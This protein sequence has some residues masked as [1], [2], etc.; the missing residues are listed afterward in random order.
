M[1]HNL[2]WLGGLNVLY[3]AS[4]FD[5]DPFEPQPNGVNRI[6]PFEW[7]RPSGD[8]FV[9]MPY[10]LPQVSTLFLV[11]R[12][13]DNAIWKR[14]LDW[15]AEQGGMALLITHPD[16]MAFDEPVDSTEYPVALYEDFLRYALDRWGSEAWF[17]TCRQVAEYAVSQ[18]QRAAFI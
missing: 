4:T 7:L 9:E 11:L 10:T 2:D 8:C 15:V 5:V 6:L 1:R 17:A 16:Y 18:S 13:K 12:E 14:K 3:D